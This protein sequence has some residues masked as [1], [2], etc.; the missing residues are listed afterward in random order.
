MWYLRNYP[1]NNFWRREMAQH[2]VYYRTIQYLRNGETRVTTPNGGRSVIEEIKIV[3]YADLPSGERISLEMMF[4]VDESTGKAT[5]HIHD[6]D[7]WFSERPIR[8]GKFQILLDGEDIATPYIVSK[9]LPPTS[10][11]GQWV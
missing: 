8:E 2:K 7:I 3:L 4:Y 9:E 6:R 10:F 5:L 11:G 1:L